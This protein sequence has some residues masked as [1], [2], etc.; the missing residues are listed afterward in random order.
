[1]D[2]STDAHAS[3]ILQKVV[4]C[5]AES[6]VL[7]SEDI[8]PHSRLST[9]LGAD[10]L[11]LLDIIFSLESQFQIKLRD[12]EIDQLLRADFTKNLT[13]EGYLSEKDV[14]ELSLWL[15]A[16]Q[17]EPNLTKISPKAIFSYITVASM[18][19]LIE[20]KISS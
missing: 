16:I 12:S 10:S 14:A 11:D 19:Q 17:E 6:L 1:M 20:K 8:L 13:E 4:N 3:D 9:D 7:S 15:P 2:T 18:V 5:L